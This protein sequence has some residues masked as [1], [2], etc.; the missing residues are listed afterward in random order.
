MASDQHRSFESERGLAL[1]VLFLLSVVSLS[2]TM[3]SVNNIYDTTT[4]QN[5]EDK[6]FFINE[7]VI[8]TSRDRDA[9]MSWLSLDRLLSLSYYQESYKA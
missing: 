7:L 4:Q 8:F 5:R 1:S 2:I 3:L 6:H 9:L